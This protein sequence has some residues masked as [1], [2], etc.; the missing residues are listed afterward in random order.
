[1]RVTDCL[2][3][4]EVDPPAED[5]LKV[6]LE[7]K[8]GVER[9][10]CTW[11]EVDEDVNI[12]VLGHEMVAGCRA[13]QAKAPNVVR[14]TRTSD[15]FT[16]HN[17]ARTHDANSTDWLPELP[18]FCALGTAQP[19]SDVDILYQLLRGRRLGWEIEDLTDELTELFGR[20]V[21]LLSRTA[22]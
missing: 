21:D 4:D 19:S 9:I 8:I 16:V 1:V 10:R 7:T 22:A 14:A 15:R 5:P 3:H 17:R 11:G 20:W 18:A 12:T 2:G 13:E 6:F